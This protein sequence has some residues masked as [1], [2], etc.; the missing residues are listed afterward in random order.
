MARSKRSGSGPSARRSRPRWPSSSTLVSL[1][2]WRASVG[3]L[4]TARG[5]SAKTATTT[6]TPARG[7]RPK[8]QRYCCC[9]RLCLTP[10][11]QPEARGR[12]SSTL[13][14]CWWRSTTT[15][16]RLRRRSWHICAAGRARG[17]EQRF[18]ASRFS[19]SS[20]TRSL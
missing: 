3:R 8:E 12:A 5:V 15:R 19:K 1:A 18:W 14:A 9:S 6:T 4:S 13:P 20:W 17:S 2:T 16:R 10:S 7:R 11:T